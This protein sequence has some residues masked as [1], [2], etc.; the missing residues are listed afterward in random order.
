MAQLLPLFKELPYPMGFRGEDGSL[1]GDKQCMD[2]LHK[3]DI[4]AVKFGHDATG[5]YAEFWTIALAC[6]RRVMLSDASDADYH[7]MLQAMEHAETIERQQSGRNYKEVKSHKDAVVQLNAK[8]YFAALRIA[9]AF[10]SH[11]FREKIAERV[12]VR[13][14][15]ESTMSKP[16]S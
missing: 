5:L 14:T 3:M 16:H 9:C 12:T 11:K 4:D 10:R 2:V 8:Q 7:E 15:M 6:A 1:P 13:Q